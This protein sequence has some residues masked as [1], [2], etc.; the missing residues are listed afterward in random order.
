MVNK[1]LDLSARQDVFQIFLQ[2]FVTMLE[3]TE[4]ELKY[5]ESQIYLV[6]W[7]L[8]NLDPKDDNAKAK[9]A[10]GVANSLFK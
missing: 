3:R 2:E 4:K 5:I 6:Y 8:K 1:K 9:P 10:W 7:A